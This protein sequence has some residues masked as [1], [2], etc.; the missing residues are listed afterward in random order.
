MNNKK[1]YLYGCIALVLFLFAGTYAYFESCYSDEIFNQ[2]TD[3]E[4]QLWV[5]YCS[6][7]LT[8]NPFDSYN[9]KLENYVIQLCWIFGSWFMMDMVLEMGVLDHLKQND[10][11][12]T[13]IINSSEL[14]KYRNKIKKVKTIWQKHRKIKQKAK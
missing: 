13:K 2:K 4:K 1:I 8:L 14:Q 3:I 9:S 5:R 10:S 6:D 7:D 11:L 12:L